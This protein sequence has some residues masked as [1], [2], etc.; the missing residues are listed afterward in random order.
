MTHIQKINLIKF[1]ELTFLLII[2]IINQ[3]MN[4]TTTLLPLLLIF[5]FSLSLSAQ[6]T[7]PVEAAKRHVETNFKLWNLKLEDVSDLAVSDSYFSKKSN[8][9]HVYLIQRYQE[10]PVR[11]ALTNITIAADGKT[12]NVGHRF[13][14]DLA[15]KINTTNPT[16][17]PEDALKA[18]MQHLSIS[19]QGDLE[20]TE[21]HGNNHYTFD[22]SDFARSPID[23]KLVFQE[24]GDVV[25]LAWD[26]AIQQKIGHDYWS[27]RVDAL[28]GNMHTMKIVVMDQLKSR[29]QQLLKILFPIKICLPILIMYL[30]FQLKVLYTDQEC[31][32]QIPRIQQPH[33]MDGMTLMV[34]LVQSSLT[35]EVTILIRIL[36][37]TTM[38]LQ[39]IRVCRM[40]ELP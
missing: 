30:P 22:Q 37:K 7:T 15:D 12:Y 26:L 25:K 11:N 36:I 33:H 13:V 39:T 16:L 34:M 20:L 2:S 9:N 14:T 40:V 17:T 23:V 1:A 3:K 29:K 38:M 21:N 6:S 28:T 35:Q 31:W 32:L 10:I 24:D 19:T 27:V 8:S 18:A 5:V 4:R